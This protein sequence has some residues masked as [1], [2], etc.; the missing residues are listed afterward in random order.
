MQV[1]FKNH[2]FNN[3]IFKSLLID[4][5]QITILHLLPGL[6]SSWHSTPSS[7]LVFY[8]GGIQRYVGYIRQF[9]WSESDIN[10]NDVCT[11][12]R[13]KDVMTPQ[14]PLRVAGWAVPEEGEGEGDHYDDNRDDQ[15]A[16]KEVDE[17]FFLKEISWTW[18]ANG[19]VSQLINLSFR[20]SLV[21]PQGTPPTSWLKVKGSCPPHNGG[22]QE[23]AWQGNFDGG[24]HFKIAPR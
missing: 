1:T 9:K 19:Q 6:G 10:D 11:R 2:C 7:C 13:A 5:D 14:N 24:Q 3:W 4:F 18:P 15:V 21:D 23:K 22:Q 8:Y 17:I 16:E 20:F 12:E